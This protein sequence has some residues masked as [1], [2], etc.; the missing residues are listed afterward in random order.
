MEPMMEWMSPSTLVPLISSLVLFAVAWGS[1][2][3]SRMDLDRRHGML[4]E[5]T[6]RDV[7]ELK[8]SKT[9]LEDRLTQ[10]DRE[11]VALRERLEGLG[12]AVNDVRQS[13]A[14]SESVDALRE[15]IGRIDGKIES[16][17]KLVTDLATRKN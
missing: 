8:A 1:E 5:E 4:A 15:V 16:L 12:H 13:K 10:L 14:S 9:R 2:R 11:A 3:Q 7:V 6:R 17:M